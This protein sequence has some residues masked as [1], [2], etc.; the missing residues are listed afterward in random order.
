MKFHWP[1]M[2]RRWNKSLT[3][4]ERNTK[5]RYNVTQ[6]LAKRKGCGLET[7][8]LVSYPITMLDNTN[9]LGMTM[10]T[11]RQSEMKPLKWSSY[12]DSRDRYKTTDCVARLTLC[13]LR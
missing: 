10:K 8:I 11:L 3:K 7:N 2:I 1:A 13:T 4:I 12:D 6:L 5:H 9:F